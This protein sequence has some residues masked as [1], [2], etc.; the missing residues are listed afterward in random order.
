MAV[1]GKG[2]PIGGFGTREEEKGGGT[3]VA[4]APKPNQKSLEGM[5]DREI[6]E[7]EALADQY[8]KLRDKRMKIGIEEVSLRETIRT[9]MKR[10][11]KTHY[12]REAIEIDLVPEGEKVKVKIHKEG[13]DEDE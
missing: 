1:R 6:E 12:R 3:A 8:A 13:E 11:K 9:T 7:L 5:E 2:A 4:E 10:H